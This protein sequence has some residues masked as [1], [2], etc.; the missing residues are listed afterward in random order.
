M[1]LDVWARTAMRGI[2]DELGAEDHYARVLATPRADTMAVHLAVFV[3]P[4][5]THVLEGRKSVESRFSMRRS[6]PFGRVSVGDVI[7]L[8]LASGPILGIC[9]VAKAWFYE[10]RDV[11]LG[12]IRDRFSDAICAHD[13]DF[14][15]ARASA[16]FATLLKL[17]HVRALSPLPC[18]KR[19]RRGWVI[20]RPTRQLS[21][22]GSA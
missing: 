4:F 11:S 15:T 19:D 9:E 1:E 7:L 5:L 3:E 17:K 16:E 13:D 2:R 10:I 6:V 12:T 18:P 20:L 21:L 22:P 14:W 8:K